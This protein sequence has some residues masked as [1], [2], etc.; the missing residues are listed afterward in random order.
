MPSDIGPKTYS[1]LS[2][3]NCGGM[4]RFDIASQRCLCLSCGCEVEPH[5]SAEQGRSKCPSCG[6]SFATD[7]SYTSRSCPYCGRDLVQVEGCGAYV[8][9]RIITFKVDKQAAGAAL[10]AETGF[11]SDVCEGHHEVEVLSVEPVYVPL[12]TASG[13]VDAQ[14]RG[15]YTVKKNKKTVRCPLEVDVSFEFDNLAADSSA[16][17]PNAAVNAMYNADDLRDAEA[18]L[19]AKTVGF[20]VEVSDDDSAALKRIEAQVWRIADEL[21]DRKCNAYGKLVT[22][23]PAGSSRCEVHPRDVALF[24][25]Y[26]ASYKYGDDVYYAAV[27]G[28]TGEVFCRRPP[29]DPSFAM[30]LVKLV[31]AVWTAVGFAPFTAAVAYSAVTRNLQSG[32]LALLLVGLFVFWIGSAL[33]AN[34]VLPKIRRHYHVAEPPL[35]AESGWKN[36]SLR[37]KVGSP[38]AERVGE[39][40]D[41]EVTL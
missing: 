41:K 34:C 23:Y 2:C 22:A 39:L 12:I 3:P 28:V 18:Y 20:P 37:N 11:F 1:S 5:G 13:R 21:V 4:P 30:R 26:H 15:R 38:S 17:M 27:S 33:T 14:Y 6:A 19:L 24:P 10:D 40:L 9:D 8:P 31:Y 36:G 32:L 25:V 16:V 35:D 29:A 7:P